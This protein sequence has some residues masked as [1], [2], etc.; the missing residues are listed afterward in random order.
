[1][2]VGVG[3]GEGAEVALTGGRGLTWLG[4]EVLVEGSRCWRAGA[5]AGGAGGT[6][7]GGG[8]VGVK[9][10]RIMEEVDRR[11][12]AC[13]DWKKVR[14]WWAVCWPEVPARSSVV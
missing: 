9:A 11:R 2:G 6:G 14:R 4:G 3:V 8:A 5:G 1:M 12:Q 7:A 13:R 10:W